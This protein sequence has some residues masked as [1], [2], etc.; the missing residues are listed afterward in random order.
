MV[1]LSF[2]LARRCHIAGRALPR[3][4]CDCGH[5]V[6]IHGPAPA[7]AGLCGMCEVPSS[8]SVPAGLYAVSTPLGVRMTAASLVMSMTREQARGLAA[9]LLQLTDRGGSDG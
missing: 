8:P 5:R 6:E 3:D 4:L 9:Y 7:S 2:V 1:E